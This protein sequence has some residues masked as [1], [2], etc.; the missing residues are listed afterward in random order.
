M[1]SK[2]LRKKFIEFFLKKGHKEMPAASLIPENDPSVLFTSAGMQQ[3]K[4]FYTQPE[5]APAK[6][7]VTCQ[8]CFRTSDIE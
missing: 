3:F 4:R 6:N 2:N 8:P 7:I 1:D 5:E